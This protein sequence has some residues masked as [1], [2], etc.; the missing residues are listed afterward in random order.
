MPSFSRLLKRFRNIPLRRI[1]VVPFLLQT[2]LALGVT[3]YLLKAH[4]DA[5]FD[6]LSQLRQEVTKR[7]EQDLL[8]YL[9]TP[10][11][12]NRINAMA[13]LNGEIDAKN[14]VQLERRFWNQLQHFDNILTLALAT[15]GKDFISAERRLNDSLVVRTSAPATDFVLRTYA[16]T[17]R[18]D[19]SSIINTGRS[20]DPLQRPWYANPVRARKPGWTIIR[21]H[22]KGK[23]LSIGLGHPVFDRKGQLQGVFLANLNLLHLSRFLRNLNINS[24]KDGQCFILN[25]SG[26]LIASSTTEKIF[27]TQTRTQPTG[28]P[29][30]EAQLQQAIGS[31]NTV[32]QA[33]ARYLTAQLGDLRSVQ[34]IQQFE[35]DIEGKQQLLQVLPLQDGRGIDWLVVVVLPSAKFMQGV[36]LKTQ[37]GILLSLFML[38]L[39]TGLGLLI[40]RWVTQPILQLSD[41]AQAIA[42]GQAVQPVTTNQVKEVNT[43]TQSFNRMAQQLRATFASLAQTNEELEVRVEERTFELTSKNEQ[44]LQEITDREKAEEALRDSQSELQ[45]MFAAM[46]DTVIVFDQEGRYLR[47]IQVPS[48]T[49]KPRLNRIGK[50]VHEVLP[51]ETAHLFFEAI[52]RALQQR[53][54]YH[55]FNTYCD[56]LPLSQTSINVEYYLPIQGKRVWFAA[57]VAPLT[58]NTVLWVAR[59]ISD[60][61]RSEQA[62]ELAKQEAETANHHKSQFLARMSH[63]LR[64]PLNVIL[65]FTQLLQQRRDLDVKQQEYLQIISRSGDHLLTLINDVL[66]LSKIEE[67]VTTLSDDRVNLNLL[68]D[69]VYQ[70][71]HLKASAKGLELTFDLASDLPST[72]R[73]DEGKLRQILINLLGNAIKFTQMGS[74]SLSVSVEDSAESTAHP[75][76][77]DPEI[78]DASEAPSGEVM[79]LPCWVQFEISD[80]GPGIDPAALDSIFEPF[81]QA[82]AGLKIQQGTGLGLSICQEFVSLMGGRGISLKSQPGEGSTFQ[83]SLPTHAIDPEQESFHSS[84]QVVGLQS[85][86]P[87]YRILVVDDREDSRHFLADLLTPLGFQ[88]QEA[89]DGEEAIILSESWFPDLIWMDMNMPVL[90]GVS[91][92]KHI[93]VSGQRS[94]VIIGLT[95][96]NLAE[97]RMTEF[98]CDCDDIIL[99]PVRAEAIFEKMAQYLGVRYRYRSVQPNNTVISNP[100]T[101]LLLS[102]EEVINVLTT[103][104]IEWVEQLHQA[105]LRVSAKQSCELIEQITQTHPS[106]ARTLNRW[107]EEYRFEDLVSATQG[108]KM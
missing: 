57:Y 35:F 30:G 108:R 39:V 93:K 18:G 102:K 87:T 6:L 64:T 50:T 28:R 83:F 67:G 49:Y 94:P 51:L 10:Y 41:A 75:N 107:V 47:Y 77:E 86:Q 55:N 89:S 88:V 5:V 38:S 91:A 13:M 24:V 79:T 58:E 74:V 43:L 2:G 32:I 45:L 101:S 25:R 23:T 31:S 44:L 99:K 36:H 100:Q 15:P 82:D 20:F 90:D 72:V 7:V 84:R 19:R 22:F 105:A 17:S 106:L 4:Q 97:D 78:G 103:M 69:W 26:F 98:S 85:G 95:G 9:E 33:T 62:I 27:Q 63:E 76:D 92:A 56:V 65:G 80:T 21:P 37:W 68:L 70:M 8:E 1:L 40:T 12:I 46:I 29:E 59:D 73:L 42:D 52:Q 53:E 104:P 3:I 16:T 81:V 61:K 14:P 71:M 48:L 54:Q 66:D 60:R 96:S 34:S 11:R